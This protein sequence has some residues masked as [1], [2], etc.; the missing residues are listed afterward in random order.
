MAER[1]YLEL[2]EVADGD[3]VY[4]HALGDRIWLDEQARIVMGRVP[5]ADVFCLGRG[6]GGR[7]SLVVEQREGKL[8]MQQAGHD[9]PVWHRG[10]PVRS[11]VALAMGDRFG[12]SYGISFVVGRTDPGP[13][14][15]AHRIGP[16][17]AFAP[18]GSGS[19]PRVWSGF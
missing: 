11:D 3:R 4:S 17:V 16:A 2:V 6:P 14:P 18:R 19:A 1:W 8:W 7:R 9:L 12:P 13:L 10:R 5:S 15:G